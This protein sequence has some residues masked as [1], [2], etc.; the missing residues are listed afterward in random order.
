MIA[1]YKC[2]GCKCCSVGISRA[3]PF[4]ASYQEF[5]SNFVFEHQTDAIPGD[6]RAWETQRQEFWEICCNPTAALLHCKKP[7]NCC[8]PG[9]QAVLI[10]NVLSP[11]AAVWI[12]S[13]DCCA[14]S[15]Q[16]RAVSFPRIC[17]AGRQNLLSYT[18]CV[19]TVCIWINCIFS[20]V[21]YN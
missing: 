19:K 18:L 21:S 1:A 20:L 12:L 7:C 2:E 6:P 9:R 17:P 14:I 4:P 10:I 3:L 16:D 8:I 11:R 15:C 5:T 13:A